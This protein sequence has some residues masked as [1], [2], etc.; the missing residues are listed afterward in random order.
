MLLYYLSPPP[1]LVFPVSSGDQHRKKEIT[2]EITWH[3]VTP[4]EKAKAEEEKKNL[5]K[6][7]ALM[8]W[9]A[10]PAPVAKEDRVFD[11]P[12]PDIQVTI[13][14]SAGLSVCVS[15][16]R[17]V[18]LCVGADALGSQTGAS[19]QRGSGFR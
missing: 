11:D 15:V 10:K 9:V 13:C 1:L 2:K 14:Q 7:M 4:E 12:E 5:K 18:N 8:P 16:C 6:Q 17:S 3:E 19:C